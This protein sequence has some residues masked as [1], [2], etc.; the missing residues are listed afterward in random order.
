M[1]DSST[2]QSVEQEAQASCDQP[3]KS[4]GWQPAGNRLGGWPWMAP[5]RTDLFRLTPEER[6][7][8]DASIALERLPQNPLLTEA[9]DALCLARERVA[10]YVDGVEPK[11]ATVDERAWL[12]EIPGPAFLTVTASCLRKRL[13]WGS[14][15]V[16]LRFARKQ[17]AEGMI[18]AMRILN[19][20]AT[21]HI[22]SS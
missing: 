18:V 19:A 15:A 17:D 7:I 6:A 5:R 16:A 4:A 22:W 1:S 12:V 20:K 13:G 14:A 21:E 10:D 3:Q 8:Y 9:V 2:A 11:K